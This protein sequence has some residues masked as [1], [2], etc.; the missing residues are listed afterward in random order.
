MTKLIKLMGSSGYNKHNKRAFIGKKAALLPII[1]IVVAAG[2]A[3]LFFFGIKDLQK[4]KIEGNATVTSFGDFLKDIFKRSEVKEKAKDTEKTLGCFT[5]V[6]QCTMQDLTCMPFYGN[7]QITIMISNTIR[8]INYGLNNVVVTIQAGDCSGNLSGPLKL[9][10]SGGA[11]P[12]IGNYTIPCKFDKCLEGN[13]TLTG[14]TNEQVGFRES[15]KF[16]IKN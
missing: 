8:K 3:A 7:G 11:G 5:K 6:D 13:I 16:S 10:G 4:Q 12:M 9:Y 1:L 14:Y 15:G 2:L